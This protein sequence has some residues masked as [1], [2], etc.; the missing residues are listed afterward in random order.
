MD[1]DLP[2]VAGDRELSGRPSSSY[3]RALLPFLLMVAVS[4]VADVSP[5]LARLSASHRFDAPPPPSRRDSGGARRAAFGTPRAGQRLSP[6]DVRTFADAPLYDPKTLRTVFIQFAGEAWEAELERNYRRDIDVAATVTIDGRVYRDVGV[7][8]RGNSSYRMVPTGFKRSLNLSLDA[9]HGDQDAGGYNTLN[10]LNGNGDATF[11]RTLLYAEI[12]QQYL[13]VPKA[14]YVR[15]AINGDSW[16]VYLNVQQFNKDFLRDFFGT[17]QGVRWKVPGSPRGRGGLEYLGDSPA[18][19]RSLYELKSKE[20]DKAWSDLMRLCRLLNTSSPED[21]EAV[22]GPHLDIDGALKFLALEIALVN[23]DGYWTRAS[24]YSLYQ[25]PAGKFHVLPYDFNEAM[26]VDGPGSRR[27][28]GHGGPTLDPLVGIDDTSKPLRSRL[29]AVPAL[30]ER[31][32]A[33]VRAMAEKSL[34]WKA[35]EPRV[36]EYQSLIEADVKADGRKLYGFD[37][38]DPAALEAFFRQR[39]EFLLR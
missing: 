18:A 27:G 21:L 14:N 26:G 39:R 31:Y 28:G 29:L 38:F 24:D 10:L 5:G 20:S 17:T 7:R 34:D 4:H 12:G 13:P 1:E 11:V 9:V 37:R 35:I 3:L 22:L 2:A 19:Y 32:L 23:T 36:R 15:V 25:D 8:F 30:R 33:Y 16:G 6:A